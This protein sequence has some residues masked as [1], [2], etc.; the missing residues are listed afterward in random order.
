MRPKLRFLWRLQKQNRPLISLQ[1]RG[2]NYLALDTAWE[3]DGSMISG[4]PQTQTFAVPPLPELGSTIV[5]SQ[6]ICYYELGEGPPLLLIHG[7]GG[8]ADEWVFCLKDLSSSNRVIALDLLGFGRSDKP[9]IRYSIDG[10][11]EVLERFLDALAIERA[12]LVGSSLGGWVA[13]AFALK[14]PGRLDSLVLV[15]AAGLQSETSRLPIDLRVSTHRHMRDVLN[16]MF[17]DQTFVTEELVD[18]AYQGHLRRQDG[19]T[20][21]SVLKHFKDEHEWLDERA[22]ELT[23]PTLI[24]WGE[25]EEL[26]PVSMSDRFHQLI[27]GSRREVIP[28]CGHLPA[29]EKPAELIRHVTDFLLRRS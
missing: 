27:Q 12:S 13:A 21:E 16:A 19:H 23:V 15:D 22:A 8:D 4:L 26:I 10:F 5:F 2:S 17:Y 7:L 20:I 1:V 29:V 6:K 11:V 25:Q 24:L 18:L 3:K 28:E 9:L 14:F